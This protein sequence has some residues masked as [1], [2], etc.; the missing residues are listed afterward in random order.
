MS[1]LKRTTLTTATVAVAALT[2]AACGLDGGGADP[3]TGDD[4]AAEG[5]QEVTGEVEGEITFQTM[6]LSPTF[7][8][9]I[10]GLIADFEDQYPD[11]S[12]EWVD[13]PTEGTAQKIAA[14]ASSG[15]LADVLDLDVATLAPL[16]RDGQVLDMAQVASDARDIYVESAWQSFE[17]GDTEASALPW[18]LNTP[19]LLANST[20]VEE[21]GLDP[22]DPPATYSELIEYSRQIGEATDSAGF[23]PTVRTFLNMMLSYGVPMINDDA[24]AAVVDTPEALQLVE[25][26]AVLYETGG[27]PADS[28]TAQ[29]RSEIETF[30]EGGAAYFDTGPSRVAIIEENAPDTFEALAVSEGLESEAEGAWVV[31]HGLAVPTTSEHQAA[32]LEFA[33]FVT[34]PENQLALAEESTVFPSAV[35]A[36]EEPFFTD[37]GDGPEDEARATAANALINDRTAPARHTA[38]DTEYEEELWSQVQLAIMGDEDPAEAL[39]RAEE[40]LTQMLERRS[41]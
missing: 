3:A 22:E 8:D 5:Q 27:I 29:P 33:R 4:D 11:V 23:Q 6:Q 41:E 25:E 40:A 12:V 2:L 16:A 14:D 10:N 37:S 13:V 30:Q 36:L 39:A 1:L 38:I 31:A 35:E 28:M 15:N 18:Y 19:V 34:N 17:F 32:A 24:T 21:A 9:F 20:I 26:L 7:D